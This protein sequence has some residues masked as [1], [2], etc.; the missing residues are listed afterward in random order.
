MTCKYLQKIGII[1]DYGEVDVSVIEG[2]ASLRGVTFPKE[3]VNLMSKH[4]GLSPIIS[5]FDWSYKEINGSNSF[6]FL[7]FGVCG[8][9]MYN[10]QENTCIGYGDYVTTFGITET[11]DRVAFDYRQDKSCTDPAILLIPC[12]CTE[13]LETG[14]T[15][16]LTI[17]VAEN[18]DDLMNKIYDDRTEEDFL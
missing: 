9:N 16:I 8:T 2:Y 17:K 10:F 11:T 4:N 6:G 5:T 12:G 15:K 13:V 1:C 18:F 14:E 3:Y 7:K